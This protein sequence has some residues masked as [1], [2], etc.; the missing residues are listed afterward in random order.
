MES[1]RKHLTHLSPVT[2]KAKLFVHELWQ[3]NVEWDELLPPELVTIWL[4]IAKAIQDIT[5]TSLSRYPFS[6]QNINPSSIQLHVFADAST[7]AYGAVS[8]LSNGTEVSIVIAKSRVAPLKKLKLPQLELV[9][10]LTGTRLA[11]FVQ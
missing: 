10:A 2:I 5:T 6:P 9:T 4:N 8:Y 11:N 3:R 7:K 1:R